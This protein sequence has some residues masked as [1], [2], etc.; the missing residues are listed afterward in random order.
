[1]TKFRSAIEVYLFNIIEQANYSTFSDEI[2]LLMSQTLLI[3]Y[4]L[5]L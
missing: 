4:V 5:F 2:H 3:I 1:M